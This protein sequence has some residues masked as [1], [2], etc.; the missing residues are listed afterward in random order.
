M[1]KRQHKTEES[2]QRTIDLNKTGKGV[3]L[4]AMKTYCDIALQKAR[5]IHEKYSVTESEK[6]TG[7]LGF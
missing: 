6:K 4:L 1:K 5:D 3:V 7:S 2:K